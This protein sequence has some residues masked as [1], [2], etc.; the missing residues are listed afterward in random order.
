MRL[1]IFRIYNKL[2]SKRLTW[3]EAKRRSNLLKH[4]LDFANALA[5]LDSRYRLDVTTQRHGETRVQSFSYA[6]GRWPC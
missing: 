2:V 3:D 4:E 5:V 1:K 6:M